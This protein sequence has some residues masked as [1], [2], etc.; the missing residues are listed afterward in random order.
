M[1]ID[2]KAPAEIWLE[3]EDSGD[4]RLWCEDNVWDEGEA[5][6]YVRADLAYE[7]A[8]PVAPMSTSGEMVERLRAIASALDKLD[9][10][11]MIDADGALSDAISAI[12]GAADLLKDLDHENHASMATIAAERARAD[13]AEARVAILTERNAIL[14]ALTSSPLYSHRA[15]TTKLHEIIATRFGARFMDPPD[16]GDVSVI[17]Q[18]ERMADALSSA[19]ALTDLRKA[20]GKG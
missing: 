8:K 20:R 14:E 11:G 16:G 13:A 2:E 6:R 3:N 1:A 7:D 4:G 18:V 12:R 10:S 15:L 17:E 5:T 19:E 9:W